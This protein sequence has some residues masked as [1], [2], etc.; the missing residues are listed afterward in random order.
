MSNGDQLNLDDLQVDRENLYREETLTDRK[1]AQIR[2]MVPVRADGSDDPDR[3]VIFSG[4]THIMLPGGPMPVQFELD[5]DN[6]EDAI[7]KF[8]E[9]TKKAVDDMV[10]RV[11]QMQ[12]EESK[13][14]VTPGDLGGGAGGP[15]GMRGGQDNNLIM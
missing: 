7:A 4:Q 11:Q 6:L 14:I 3:T 8:P 2:R 15:G 10:E 9:A 1:V 13:R 5:A 12:R